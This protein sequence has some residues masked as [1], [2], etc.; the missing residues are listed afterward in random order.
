MERRTS[1]FSPLAFSTNHSKLDEAI[2][3]YRIKPLLTTGSIALTLGA[4]LPGC[5][6][7]ET[8]K[9]TQAVAETTV[10]PAISAPGDKPAG[11]IAKAAT[12]TAKVEA[13]NR[14]K[15][16][17]TLKFPDGKLAQIKCG[18]DIRNFSQI[19]VGDD[20]TVEFLESVE[21]VVT[22]PSGKPTTERASSVKQ[23][24]HKGKPGVAAAKAVEV[25]ATVESIDY[26]TRKVTLKGPEGKLASVSVGP[27]VKQFDEI[28]PGDTVVARYLEA[29]S[30]KVSAPEQPEKAP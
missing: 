20:V 19:Q 25:T 11:A 27:E 6:T 30:I 18:P 14:K 29:A 13:I 26:H 4:L 7:K 10:V 24:P 22:G 16:I 17:V 28:K 9:P 8:P 3:N 2:M 23:A 15:R 5:T 1:T 12:V 21:L